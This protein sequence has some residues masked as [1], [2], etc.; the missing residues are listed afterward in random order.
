MALFCAEV[1][2]R[3]AEAWSC[4]H[5]GQMK[6]KEHNSQCDANIAEL[7]RSWVLQLRKGTYALQDI[8][9]PGSNNVK[10]HTPEEGV[11][12]ANAASAAA[13]HQR[14]EGSNML[15]LEQVFSADFEEG[16]ESDESDTNQHAHDLDSVAEDEKQQQRTGEQTPADGEKTNAD[17]DELDDQLNR[18]VALHQQQQQ[19]LSSTDTAS[20]ATAAHVYRYANT[21]RAVDPQAFFEEACGNRPAMEFP[22]PLDAFQLEAMA[23]I[24]HGESVFVAAHTSAGKTAPAEYALSLTKQSC[25]KALYTSPVKTLSNQKY[26]D[27]KSNGFDVGLLTGDTQINPEASALVLT[28]EILR[29]MLYRGSDR[30][31]DVEWVVFDEVHY[32]NDAERGVV[33]EEAL[34]LLPSRVKVLMLS[35]TVPNV[36]EFAEW[37]GRTREQCIRVVQTHKRPVPLKHCV[38][39]GTELVPVSEEGK[40]LEGK[41]ANINKKA[42]ADVNS[43]KTSVNSEGGNRWDGLVKSLKE[44]QLLPAIVFVFSKA[45]ADKAAA[46]V[47]KQRGL[48]EKSQRADVE[49]VWRKA[50]SRLRTADKELPQI[51]TVKQLNLNG[52]GVHH[53]GLLP[54]VKE[55]VEMLFCKGCIKALFCTETF[56]LGVN[57]PAKAVVFSSTK[58]HDG[59]DFRQLKPG[60]YTQM[61]GRAGRR[62]LDAEGYV[63]I[64][65]GAPAEL[66][67]LSAKDLKEM[68]GGSASKL[69]SKFRITF[70][71]V[72]S[73]LQ[74]E[75]L[76]AEGLMRSSFQEFNGKQA[77]QATRL[78]RIRREKKKLSQLENLADCE[79]EASRE[80]Y[81]TAAQ[82]LALSQE[83]S[84]IAGDVLGHVLSSSS[85]S[86]ATNAVAK[87][88]KPGRMLQL[89]LGDSRRPVVTVGAVLGVFKHP[90]QNVSKVQRSKNTEQRSN[91]SKLLS[92]NAASQS[93]TDG[94]DA[95][96]VLVALVPNIRDESQLPKPKHPL[97]YENEFNAASTESSQLRKLSR[98]G[99][100]DDEDLYARPSSK[101]VNKK[102]AS[103]GSDEHN[104]ASEVLPKANHIPRLVGD[105]QHA[106]V[107]VTASEIVGVLRAEIEIPQ[108]RAVVYDHKP[109]AMEK[110]TRALDKQLAQTSPE[111][112]EREK[113][114]RELK[115]SNGFLQQAAQDLDDLSI[116]LSRLPSP[117]LGEE[118]ERQYARLEAVMKQQREKVKSLEA[119]EQHLQSMSEFEA[120]E[121]V[122]R[123]V[124]AISERRRGVQTKGRVACELTAFGCELL[125]AETILRGILSPLDPSEMAAVLSCFVSSEKKLMEPEGIADERP[126]LGSALENVREL[127]WEIGNLQRQCHVET[128]T[129]EEY[130]ASSFLP[131]LARVVLMWADGHEFSE[132]KEHT[133]AQEGGIV[134]CMVRLDEALRGVRGA[135]RVMGDPQLF[136]KSM[137]AEARVKRDI[138][139]VP[140]LWLS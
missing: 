12:P 136:Q 64:A 131:G 18:I 101:G 110:A 129:P 59:S 135:A 140:S 128:I 1:E 100:A 133:E 71:T 127:A 31:R 5:T 37:V 96:H 78:S 54:I 15:S 52:V 90:H 65:P 104:F 22:Y 139:F 33:W 16:F 138:A 19:H 80:A 72:L 77:D 44:K 24:E 126:R 60:E 9:L 88:L 45:K 123:H 105:G 28:T 39:Y 42:R 66:A 111:Q 113:L 68:T 51:Q 74:T 23:H 3:A 70:G 35:A 121:A 120:K 134:K 91:E 106:V 79:R 8:D 25:A 124:G 82:R 30:I 13:Q 112:L 62:G 95:S 61:A 107:G 29:S 27:L 48:I 117:L 115:L 97:V 34:I 86:T 99:D 76:T 130:V 67:D 69:S 26:S 98:K 119:Q 32:V 50:L 118:K 114:S 84:K 55:V 89:A 14:E 58:K 2:Q 75:E 6:E 57:A 46:A 38:L 116:Q 93:E 81:E 108:P 41:W 49:T 36:A 73:V 4:A 122:L 63:I 53:A 132:V 17:S 92:S 43:N 94:D 109:Q 11:R 85:S 87:M 83:A 21:A 7:A 103:S 10:Q 125:G 20:E 40:F 102:S 47:R 137:D 56:A